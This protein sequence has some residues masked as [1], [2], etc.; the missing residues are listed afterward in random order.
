MPFLNVDVNHKAFPRRYGTLVDLLKEMG[1]RSPNSTLDRDEEEKLRRHLAGL[2]IVYTA[3]NANGMVYKF[4]AIVDK[5][6]NIR[7]TLDNGQ[8]KSILQYF[9]DTGRRIQY[10]ELNCIKLGNTIKN[11]SVVIIFRF[12]L[13]ISSSH[14]IF[15]FV[16][17]SRW[18][19]VQSRTPR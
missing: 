2:E 9:N 19:S 3:P 14:Y 7:F 12:F 13:N 1:V 4:M 10:P 18:S 15:C 5:P 16:L 11:I 6:A 8:Q 17:I